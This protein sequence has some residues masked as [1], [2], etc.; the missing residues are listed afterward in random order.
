MD[1]QSDVE[2]VE[3]VNVPLP[4]SA[5]TVYNFIGRNVENVENDIKILYPDCYVT[6]LHN[7][8][9]INADYDP[10]RIVLKF[11]DDRNVTKI[12]FG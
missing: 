8:H 3:S 4:V 1:W 2:S 11:D 10:L 7:I 5:Q 6:L 9:Q 12:V